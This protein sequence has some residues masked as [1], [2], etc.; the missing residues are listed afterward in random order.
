VWCKGLK[1][2]KLI[3]VGFGANFCGRSFVE[4]QRMRREKVIKKMRKGEWWGKK[5]YQMQISRWCRTYHVNIGTMGPTTVY[6]PS[7]GRLI[8]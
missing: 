8:V 6:I 5:A 7:L 3:N 4:S 2:F 1:G